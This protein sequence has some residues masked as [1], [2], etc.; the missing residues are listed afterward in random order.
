MKKN[1]FLFILFFLLYAGMN[2]HDLK[3][4]ETVNPFIGVS[5]GGNVFPGACLPFSKV[6]LSP[7]SEFKQGT[8]GYNSNS[9][10]IG[11][12]HTHSS[13][14]GGMGRYGNFLVF[15]Q[16]GELSVKHF[17]SEIKN[18]QASAGFYS[19]VL[20]EGNI[21]AELTL[22]N[23]H[24]GFHKYI[25]D[26][27]FD[28]LNILLL[29]SATRKTIASYSPPSRCIQSEVTITEK[30]KV[31]GWGEFI[32][33][34]GGKNP[35]KIY[36]SAVF[37]RCFYDYGLWDNEGVYEKTKHKKNVLPDGQDSV[38][39]GA[40]FRFHTNKEIQLKLAISY[41]SVEKAD[42]YL[43][44]T[45]SWN[46]TNYKY[47]TQRKWNRRLNKIK[48]FGGTKDQQAL[49]YTGLYHA[50]IMPR[51]LTGDNPLW[52]SEAPH[53]WDYYC[54]WDTYRSVN[55]LFMLIDPKKQAEQINCLLDIYKHKGWLPDAWTGGD[56]GTIQGG[57]NVDVVLTEAILK[58][59]GGFDEEL[60]Y[61]AMVKNATVNPQNSHKNGR[62][63]RHYLKYKYLP[64]STSDPY[65]VSYPPCPSSRTLEYSYNDFCIAQAAHKLGYTNDCK[66][67]MERSLYAFNLYN[68][69]TGFFWAKDKS[70]KW[71][72]GFNPGFHY[73]PWRGAFYEGT[74]YHY[75]TSVPHHIEKLIELH[76]G[77]ENFV[78]F[79][80][81]I[82][83][84]NYYSHSNQPTIHIAWL[85]HYAGRPDKS[86]LR[87]RNIL[88]K[89]YKNAR[90]GLPGNDDA[91]TMSAWYVL[92][93][94]GLY[95]VPG[96]DIYLLNSPLFKKSLINVGNCNKL[97]VYCYK[98]SEKNIYIKSAYLN[99]KKLDKSWLKHQE[100]ENGGLLIFEM[101]DK[102]AGWGS[103]N[104]PPSFN[105]LLGPSLKD[106]MPLMT[107]NTA[108]RYKN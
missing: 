105:N 92:A 85:Y 82:F 38:K 35:H 98:F 20:K 50:S 86:S 84:N 25:P 34:W 21:K 108:Y 41:T 18:E 95:P 5:G 23:E 93:S 14:T 26:N 37:D 103:E 68:P 9:P 99:G 69:E 91:G 31:Q 12:S 102:P 57:S 94:L 40:Y 66:N 87:I 42:E 89:K 7:D 47:L 61:E 54:I 55:P 60:A 97:L 17:S 88:E 65:K 67:F 77:K 90:H 52:D 78:A 48:V 71:I 11:F 24:V 36:F 106:M 96:Q 49:F 76:G 104:L 39:L 63:L 79:L 15:P 27:E 46:F 62:Y 81:K 29:A 44:E 45:N 30:N 74:P 80:D 58:N 16:T 6:S 100:I 3:L 101:D 64:I 22:A 19:T 83:D 70:G 32:G 73:S 28:T 13:G 2:K 107:E 51:D 53:F 1:S 56:Y 59:I 4:A 72:E 8:S 75:S 33:G 43:E 10:I